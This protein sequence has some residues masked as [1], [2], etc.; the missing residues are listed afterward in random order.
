VVA[1]TTQRWDKQTIEGRDE[2]GRLSIMSGA[3]G[4]SSER[5][6]EL[7]AQL[8]N[9]VRAAGGGRFTMAD[10]RYRLDAHT[11]RSP[12]PPGSRPSARRSPGRGASSG[13]SAP[14]S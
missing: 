11:L 1:A 8:R 7:L 13:A 14:T 2:A 12:M 6:A 3:G 5:G 10:G 4:D 9:R